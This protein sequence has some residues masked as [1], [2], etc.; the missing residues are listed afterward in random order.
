MEKLIVAQRGGRLGGRLNS[1]VNAL[2][3]AEKAGL[4][5]RYHWPLIQDRDY[6]INRV[7]EL[8]TQRFLR[9]NMEAEAFRLL[10]PDL[11]RLPRSPV[12]PLEALAE[13]CDGKAGY[14]VNVTRAQVFPGEDPVQVRRELRESFRRLDFLPELKRAFEEIARRMEG[15]AAVALH[16][17]RGDLLWPRFRWVAAGSKYRPT[18]LYAEYL[19]RRLAAGARECFLVFSDD[20]ETLREL[21]RSFP[22]LRSQEDF[23]D[24][25]RYSELQLAVLDMVLMMH[26]RQIVGP[27]VSAFSNFAETLSGTTLY[28]IADAFGTQELE[29]LLHASLCERLPG[30]HEAGDRERVD[31]VMD[32]LSAFTLSRKPSNPQR[33]FPAVSAARGFDPENCGIEHVFA[34]IERARGN[35]VEAAFHFRKAWEGVRRLPGVHGDIWR[36]RYAHDAAASAVELYSSGAALP[37]PFHPKRGALLDE[38]LAL[39]EAGI[40]IRDSHGRLEAALA[41]LRLIRGEVERAVDLLGTSGLVSGSDA[42]EAFKV[43]FGR[44]L[45][46]FDEVRR[47]AKRHLARAVKQEG[48]VDL[49]SALLAYLHRQDAEEEAAAR[50]LKRHPAAGERYAWVHPDPEGAEGFLPDQV[51]GEMDDGEP[52]RAKAE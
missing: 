4:P 29:D 18:L 44:R 5:F 9:E 21:K 13:R 22:E 25:G 43:Y 15:Q 34:Q 50:V 24:P 41:E 32:V 1:L 42:S 45:L 14:L 26:C 10:L 3:L 11:R 33:W 30:F 8:F 49:P 46:A 17:R 31:F 37:S 28:P 20:A 2:R 51:D 6:E 48:E 38:A 52:E 39:M 47:I 23:F 40:A 27:G 7:E 19:R 36:Q 16:I 35:L 12:F